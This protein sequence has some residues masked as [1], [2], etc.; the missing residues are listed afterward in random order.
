MGKDQEI[1]SENTVTPTKRIM[2][3]DL[4]ATETLTLKN[5]G[6]TVTCKKSVTLGAIRDVKNRVTDTFDQG[7]EILLLS[8]VD[9]DL[10]ETE[11]KKADI[12]FENVLKIDASDLMYLMEKFTPS[13]QGT[14]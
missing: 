13:K 1:T 6:V 5:S 12:S 14:K 7:I 3:Q 2:L 8:I 4:K 11:D 10:Y 9:W